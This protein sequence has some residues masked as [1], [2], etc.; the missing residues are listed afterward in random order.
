M[1]CLVCKAEFAGRKDKLYC[2]KKCY[3]KA[4]RAANLNRRREIERAYNER[5]PEHLAYTQKYHLEKRYGLS[6]RDFLNMLAAQN[7]KCKIC[8]TEISARGDKG[9]LAHVDHNHVTN[10]VR[11]ALCGNCNRGLGCF[12]DSIE[13]LANAIA[14]LALKGGDSHAL[15]CYD[16][17]AT[18]GSVN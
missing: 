17:P 14:Y 11:G 4:Y 9:Q 18:A 3:A 2:S 10:M 1:V 8:G 16:R 12:K 5:H 7:H 6:E 15:F 13:A